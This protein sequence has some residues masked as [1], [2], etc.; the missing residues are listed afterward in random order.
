MIRIHP[1]SRPVG[2]LVEE[3]F[4]EKLETKNVFS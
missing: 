1:L 4:A 2:S 3:K